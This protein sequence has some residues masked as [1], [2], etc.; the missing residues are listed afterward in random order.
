[1]ESAQDGLY[2]SPKKFAHRGKTTVS[3]VKSG[4]A[5]KTFNRIHPRHE[6][7][8]L[9]IVL[10]LFPVVSNADEEVSY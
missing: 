2:D 9:L 3:K 4:E 5:G 1:M 10:V 6:R 7:D 8:C